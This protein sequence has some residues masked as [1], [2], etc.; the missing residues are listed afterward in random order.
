[1]RFELSGHIANRLFRDGKVVILQ[2][3]PTDAHEITYEKVQYKEREIEMIVGNSKPGTL[4]A[5]SV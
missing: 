5:L 4:D 1:V 2:S 3:L